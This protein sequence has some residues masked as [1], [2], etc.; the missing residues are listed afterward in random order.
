ML[1]LI[2]AITTFIAFFPA[3]GG[4][5]VNYDDPKLVSL[6]PLIQ[7]LSWTGI[8]A[9]FSS[10]PNMSYKPLVLLSYAVEYHLFGLDP[11]VFH[12]NNVVL[13]IFNSLFIFYLLRLLGSTLYLSF[14]VSLLFALHPMH[15][16]SVAWISERKD[17]LSMFF[18]LGALITY[19]K[20]SR[21]SNFLFLLACLALFILALISKMMAI[22]LPFVLFLFDH[23]LNKK[24]TM[25]DVMVYL[26]FVGIVIILVYVLGGFERM[27]KLL[28]Y[29]INEVGMYYGIIDTFLIMCYEVCFYFLKTIFPTS[30]SAIYPYPDG[31][32][33]R[34]FSFLPILMVLLLFSIYQFRKHR[35]YSFGMGLTLI[36]MLPVL[37]LFAPLRES[38]TA[39]NY[40]YLPSFGIIFLLANIYIILVEKT[41]IQQYLKLGFPALLTFLFV[42]QT[43]ERSRVWQTS[44]TLWTDVIQKDEH[45]LYAYQNRA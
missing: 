3:L 30:L 4:E 20:Y 27:G 26:P 41:S 39:N 17:V 19:V 10:Y 7:D 13:H 11:Y 22:S 38:I 14:L 36:T 23:Y 25:K 37:Q 40:A 44:E 9:I 15:V 31:V 34:Y 21:S 16:E 29:S 5:F 35:W 43:Q 12:L 32:L 6:N 2:I 24:T 45:S 8:K 1:L 33:P 18:Y 42:Y 28:S